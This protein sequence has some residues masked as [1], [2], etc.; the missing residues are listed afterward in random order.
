MY[1]DAII[2]LGKHMPGGQPDED[3][4]ARAK[5]AADCWING[6]AP[7]VIPCG[8]RRGGE[9]AADET[10]GGTDDAEPLAS[11]C[12]ADWL[13]SELMRLGVPPTV[14]HPERD[15]L[16]TSQNLANAKRMMDEWGGKT[17]LIVTS[18]THMPRALAVSRSIGLR[19]SGWPV[20]TRESSRFK[21]HLA[22][23]LGWIEWKLGWQRD[24]EPDWFARI[25]RKAT[26]T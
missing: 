25:V 4:L 16:N 12:E 23:W 7:A 13:A 6:R 24:G 5:A 19:A 9:R 14:I 3:A 10:P 15:S 8:G 17:A 22:E 26:G 20:T 21:A 1:A 11:F 2:V 18:A